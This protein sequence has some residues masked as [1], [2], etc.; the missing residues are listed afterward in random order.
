M[1]VLT[2]L[3]AAP[4]Y[5]FDLLLRPGRVSRWAGAVWRRRRRD[6]TEP[7]G[8]PVEQLA[9]QLRRL[10]SVRLDSRQVS[11]VRWFGVER[12]YDETLGK[13]CQALG[14]EHH[15]DDVRLADR[16]FERLRV[17]AM[18]ENA[19]L[20][21]RGPVGGCGGRPEPGRHGRRP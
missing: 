8:P 20:V 14:V 16:E 18:L 12:A 10:S 15:L 1:V 13:A 4:I 2:V 19:G 9:A 7:A 5:L 6:V 21:L 11:S 3:A 17:E